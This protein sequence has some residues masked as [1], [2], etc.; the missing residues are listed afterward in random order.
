MRIYL[1]RQECRVYN[2]MLALWVSL[3]V[4]QNKGVSIA[5]IGVMKQSS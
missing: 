5:K 3:L 4:A 2:S 1:L